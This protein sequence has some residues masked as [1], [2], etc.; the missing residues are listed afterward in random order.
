MTSII[1]NFTHVD[2]KFPNSTPERLKEIRDVANQQLQES[3]LNHQADSVKRF[4]D[5]TGLEL[6]W[7]AGPKSLSLEAVY[8]FVVFNGRL[9]YHASPNLAIIMT[10]LNYAKG[11]RPP[12]VLPLIS[13]WLND[14]DEPD[15]ETRKAT[16]AWAFNAL[17]NASIMH[18]A[19]HTPRRHNF[20][21]NEVAKWK[22]EKQKAALQVWRTGTRCAEVNDILSDKNCSNKFRPLGI[23]TKRFESTA[24]TRTLS[25]KHLSSW[26]KVYA[27]LLR[28]AAKY[29]LSRQEFEY[30]CTI[31]S[32]R[33][34]ECRVF[35]PYH[36]LSR[37]EAEAYGW[38]WDTLEAGASKYLRTLR[39]QCNRNA[40]MA[41]Y[42]ES[43]VDA[44]IFIY[45][46]ATHFSDKIQKLKIDRP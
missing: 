28:I 45:W 23:T 20:Q 32:P 7:T 4:C 25:S 3:F 10:S 33:G 22:P 27:T 26:Q 46:M 18:Q 6:S 37:P 41:G 31:P 30:Y 16:W 13:V 2:K 35:Y 8:R 34:E 43:Q 5:Y 15:F 11:G 29:G 21:L 36:M 24:S 39:T 19:L 12:I 9:G 14:H 42:G 17:S 38:D 44:T 1:R 40:E